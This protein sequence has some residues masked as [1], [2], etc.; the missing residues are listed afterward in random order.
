M[1][2]ASSYRSAADD[3]RRTS[4]RLAE[5]AV[6]HRRTDATLIGAIGAV[7]AIHD[8]S[9]DTAGTHLAVAAHEAARLAV[10]CD[11]RADVCDDYDRQ[12]A[13]WSALPWHERLVVPRPFPPARWVTG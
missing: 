1:S 5:V 3:L 10:E 2:R 8:R 4:D 12:V 13:S 7:A 9:I 6:V 11:R